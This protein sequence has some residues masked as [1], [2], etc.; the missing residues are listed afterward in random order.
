MTVDPSNIP[1][2]VA[3]IMD[4]NRRWAR[5]KNIPLAMGHWE[6]AEILTDIVKE[7]SRIGVKTLTVYSF[8]TEN[9]TR[10]SEEVDSIMN[11]L[12]VYLEK[13]RDVMV[14]DGVKL[15]AI[16]NLA[17]LPPEV[18]LAFEHTRD[19]T[20]KCNKINLVLAL[21]YGGRDEIRRAI[22][23]L[24]ALK[25]EA[26]TEELIAQQMDTYPYGDPELVIRTSGEYRVSNFLLW[27]ISYAEIY[28]TPVLWPEF[29]PKHFLEAISHFQT[30]KRRKGGN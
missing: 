15:N 18:Q 27:Q 29:L 12:K 26:I 7:A 1:D 19:A 13:K 22:T 25:P 28:T 23:K 8:S 5:Q 30:R 20:A 14:Q 6:G 11:I 9:W 24:I 10:P 21:N 3:I 17:G 2:H 4:G 16:G